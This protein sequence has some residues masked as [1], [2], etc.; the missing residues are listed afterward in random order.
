[1]RTQSAAGVWQRS[2]GKQGLGGAAAAC[3]Q[4]QRLYFTHCAQM[5]TN[6]S[7]SEYFVAEAKCV[8]HVP[9]MG[10]V[11]TSS[12]FKS[13][14]GCSLRQVEMIEQALELA[15]LPGWMHHLDYSREA[16]V[17]GHH[18][19]RD[20]EANVG[21][22]SLQVEPEKLQP[23]TANGNR[24]EQIYISCQ[25]GRSSAGLHASHRAQ[26][27]EIRDYPPQPPPLSRRP[28]L[29]WVSPGSLAAVHVPSH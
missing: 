17:V 24:L 12:S 8:W 15:P 4:E 14:T 5:K 20:G 16:W 6:S 2:A 21:I 23:P 1:M 29:A 19:R 9:P 26:D 28:Q 25:A 27:R 22:V 11:S 7:Y 3:G 13:K 10:S 18:P